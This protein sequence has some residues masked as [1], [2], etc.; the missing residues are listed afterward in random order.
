M[1]EVAEVEQQPVEAAEDP[2]EVDAY[3]VEETQDEVEEI[4]E[5]PSEPETPSVEEI[6]KDL[7]WRPKDEFQGD[8]ENYVDPVTYI[9]RSKD[10]QKS[11]SQ[12]L[13]ENRRKLDDMD[14][15]VRDL[16]N[17]YE[18]VS[19]AQ[20]AKQQKEIDR[21]RKEKKE[22][23]AEGDA[24][25][26]DQIEDEMLDHY[27]SIEENSLPPE[28][29][30][31]NHEEV[32]VFEGWHSKNSWYSPKKGIPGDSEM[33]EYANKLASLPEYD[34][35]PY[36][37]RLATVEEMVKKAFPDKFPAQQKKQPGP[38]S[39]PVESPRGTS[40]KRQYTMRDLN[41]EQRDM[42]RNFVDRGIMTEKE[43]IKQLAEA[44]EIG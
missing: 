32:E 34:A 36:K 15:A 24:D 42:V 9:K 30:S 16:H 37:R 22:A 29:P 31:Y 27:R 20:I 1:A 12:H 18:T 17:H 11:M 41:K 25:R 23:I 3:E 2:K 13:K 7:G 4:E 21:L 43:Y 19:K 6:A 40:T 8:D 33:T 10:I 35:L 14:R 5:T 44:G 38:T 39:N 28:Q 26:V